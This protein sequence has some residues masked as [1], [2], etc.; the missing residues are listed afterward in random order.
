VLLF[1]P[2]NPAIRAAE[3]MVTARQGETVNLE[4]YTSGNPPPSG[5]MIT[6]RRNNVV[7]SNNLF[8]VKHRLK[9]DNVQLSDAGTYNVSITVLISAIQGLTRT[10]FTLLMLKVIGESL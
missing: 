6:W 8:D 5:G 10:K 9:I 4:I 1:S 3:P 2:D 7:V